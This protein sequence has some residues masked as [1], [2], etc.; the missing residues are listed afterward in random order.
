MSSR[1]GFS[2]CAEKSRDQWR[3][4]FNP[5][6]HSGRAEKHEFFTRFIL[7]LSKDFVLAP[8]KDLAVSF[9][10]FREIHPGGCLLLSDS[11]FL[12]AP[13]TLPCAAV[14]RY[15]FILR[16]KSAQDGVRTFLSVKSNHSPCLS[17]P[18]IPNIKLIVKFVKRG[19]K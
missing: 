18:I 17:I 13:R 16:R 9:P 8:S 14:S 15:F 1:S 7:S 2:A 4:T 5:S 10:R 12:F 11:T 19:K 3:T 6:M